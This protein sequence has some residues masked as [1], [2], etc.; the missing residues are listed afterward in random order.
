MIVFYCFKKIF[1][2]KKYEIKWKN[3]AKLG[4]KLIFKNKPKQK[5][6]S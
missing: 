3:L 1:T 2:Y 6:V 4:L 5:R